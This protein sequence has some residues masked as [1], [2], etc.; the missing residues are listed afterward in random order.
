[1]MCFAAECLLEGGVLGLVMALVAVVC[2][3]VMP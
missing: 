1:M 3:A 2:L